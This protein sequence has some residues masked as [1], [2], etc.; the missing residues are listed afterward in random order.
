M[1]QGPSAARLLAACFGQPVDRPPVWMMRQAGRYLPEYRKV[2][3]RL[4]FLELCRDADAAAEVSLQPFRRF[5]PDGVIFFSDILIPVEA[6]GLPVAF[7]DAGPHLAEPVR[8]ASDVAKLRRFDPSERIGF[9]GEILRRLR[10]EVGGAAA[11]LG[12]CGAP[13]TLASYMIEGSGSKSFAVIKTMMLRDPATLR[14]L[15]DLCADVA[16]EVLSFQI[17]SGAQ[18]VQLFDTWAGEL[19]PEDYKEWALPAARR[20]IAGIRRQGAPVILYVNGCGGILEEMAGSGADVLSVDWR[21]P[22]AEARRRVPGKALQGNLD[23]AV[24]LGTPEETRRRT[25]ALVAQTGGRAHI[26][27]LGHGVL[28]SAH[29]ECVEAFFAAARE[30]VA[31]AEAVEA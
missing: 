29:I 2:R 15:L 27:N 25:R 9:T 8:S 10:R 26:V 16:A 28:P 23:P 1:S 21:L 17:A 30:P 13:W 4:P 3:E 12:F 5:A 31:V 14:Q 22:I 11:V 19:S 18:A 24:L 20:A 7:G 6:M